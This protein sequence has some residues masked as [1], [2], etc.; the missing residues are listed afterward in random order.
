MVHEKLT[1]AW[2]SRSSSRKKKTLLL[3]QLSLKVS[4]EQKMTNRRRR[5]PWLLL[6]VCLLSCV[7]KSGFFFCRFNWHPAPAPPC[8]PLQ[9][10]LLLLP[11]SSRAYSYL[12]YNRPHLRAYN[13][14]G[15]HL[16]IDGV[17]I[18]LVANFT[19]CNYCALLLPLTH[20]QRL[21]E[22]CGRF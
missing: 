17:V 7:L 12:Y 5:R 4:L 22:W 9:Q 1:R 21:S 10:L 6:L 20:S 16:I 18:V 15:W 11:M 14:R 8:R 13:Y 3:L 19:G 2:R